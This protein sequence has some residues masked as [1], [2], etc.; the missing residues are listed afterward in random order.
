MNVKRRFMATLTAI[1]L[2]ALMLS[3][4]LAF[5]QIPPIPMTVN[6]YVYVKNVVTE[7]FFTAP[8]GLIV[9][10][11]LGLEEVSRT[12]LDE[13]GYYI[14]A[15]SGPPEGSKI[16]L[17]VQ[18][19]NVTRITL[20]YYAV[21]ELNL[22]VIDVEPPTAPTELIHTSPLNDTTP[23]FKWL[24]SK[25]NLRVEGYYVEIANVYPA[26]WIGNVTSWECPVTLDDGTYSVSV[27]AKDLAGNNGTA[28]LLEFTIQTLPKPLV[29]FYAQPI[30]GSEPLRV[31]FYDNSTNF[32]TIVSWLW[33]FGD[34][35]TSTERNPVHIY[36]QD[37]AYTVTLTVKG[38]DLAGKPVEKSLTK[39]SYV[40]VLDTKPIA[41]FYAAPLSGAKPLTVAFYD[42]S[43]SYDGI[44]SWLWDFGDGSTS[45]ERN[46]VHI[47]TRAGIYPVTLTVKEADGDY[48]TK[49]K[50]S[51]IVVTEVVRGEV[52][53]IVD[54]GS[55]HFRGEIAEFYFATTYNGQLVN[56]TDIKLTLYKPPYGTA[57]EP[58]SHIQLSTGLYLA[59]Y[60]I[61]GDATPGTYTLLI[62]VNYTDVDVEAHGT[63]LKSF[64]V[65]PSLTD[66]NA[67]IIEINGTIAEVRTDVGMIR[68]N[69][70]AIDAKVAAIN[71]TVVTIS[72]TLGTVK[73]TVDAIRATVTDIKNGVATISTDV[74]VIKTDVSAIRPVI[75]RIDGNVATISTDV[76]TIK[77]DVSAIRPVIT[78]IK[79]GIAT[80]STDV[81]VIK[82]RVETIDGNV[83]V[84]RTDVGT[85]KAEILDVMD[86]AE[87][88]KVA[89]EAVATPLYVAVVLALIAAIASIYSIIAIRRKIAG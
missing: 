86:A 45:T 68:L 39:T 67:K 31:Q 26:T 85:I 10:A 44:V 9:H 2:M 77:V 1:L 32:G 69:L 79:N 8:K 15:I 89:A 81:G 48:D 12:T 58:L 52:K 57:T 16:D 29:D 73:T 4:P 71:G 65:S 47:Y 42:N 38:T 7:E 53:V 46:P 6:G 11:K 87:S 72:T 63:T 19:V 17:W 27:W 56:A 33:D 28:A 74:G 49:T 23:S 3:V 61:P 40:V 18:G 84:I 82:G 36:R 20:Q 76:G 50:L 88:A 43:T 62:E 83:A 60:T 37:G 13:N 75:T 22:T 70:T 14:L 21:V 64:I 35:S 41:D 55:I 30:S 5:A 25:D 59:T 80:I 51:Y 34:G 24:P 66:W 54:V 78:E